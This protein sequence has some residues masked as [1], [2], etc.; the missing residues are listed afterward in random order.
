MA[1]NPSFRLVIGALL[2][3][4]AGCAVPYSASS[5]GKYHRADVDRLP[6]GAQTKPLMFCPVDPAI[7]P[8]TPHLDSP[9]LSPGDR[10]FLTLEDGEEFAGSYAVGTDGR[11][12]IPYLPA[13][14]VR[15][16][17][18][19]EAR[20]LI[21][22]T[23]VTEDM[24][25]DAGARIGLVPQLWAAVQVNVSGAVFSPGV[26]VINDRTHVETRPDMKTRSGDFAPDRYFAAAL[27]A[28]G[29]LRPDAALARA[30]L[31]RDGREST[32]DLRPML[33][34]SGASQPALLQGDRIA[35]PSVGYFQEQ[36]ARPSSLTPPG[37]RIY[38]SN[39]SIPSPSNA[40]SSIAGEATRLP[41]GSR[42]SHALASANCIG[43]TQTT[44]AHRSALLVTK[45]PITSEVTSHV[46]RVYEVTRYADDP[47][48]NPYLL[49][50]DAV[51]CFDSSVSVVRDLARGALDVLLP[52]EVLR[53]IQ[54][55]GFLYD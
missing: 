9:R 52:I 13:I 35:I 39:L 45:N 43:G 20:D 47:A 27:R 11:L 2:L 28:A 22:E 49:P 12:R 42:L 41:T 21:T 32:I 16:L 7:A 33:D 48:N 29:G 24:L 36:L 18:I 10:M 50:E 37:F 30:T 14:A 40:Q 17:L 55:G 34:G 8:S 23:L 19:E 15:G 4:L 53:R 31:I 26:V 6:F 46:Y 5:E 38:L 54:S 25:T 51:A 44:N 1:R 3:S